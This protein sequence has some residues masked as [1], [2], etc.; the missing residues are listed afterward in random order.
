MRRMGLVAA[1]FVACFVSLVDSV[2]SVEFFVPR[3]IGP[4]I[5]RSGLSAQY[6]YYVDNA[7]TIHT[8]VSVL[9]GPT[10]VRLSPASAQAIARE[11]AAAVSGNERSKTISF[12]EGTCTYLSANN[13][14]T[15]TIAPTGGNPATLTNNDI[16]VFINSCTEATT[17]ATTWV[18]QALKLQPAAAPAAPVAPPVPE[19]APAAPVAPAAE[20]AVAED[21][22]PPVTIRPWL[23]KT[24]PESVMGYVPKSALDYLDRGEQYVHT[25]YKR[26]GALAIA[27]AILALLCLIFFFRGRTHKKNAYRMHEYSQDQLQDLEKQYQKELSGASNRVNEMSRQIQD[28]EKKHQDALD[29]VKKGYAEN[30]LIF[31]NTIADIVKNR[32]KTPVGV[33]Q[34]VQ[35]LAS[36]YGTASPVKSLQDA[37][38]KSKGLIK[39]DRAAVCDD[40]DDRFRRSAASFLI[41][42]FNT[43]V[44]QAA[45]MVNEGRGDEGIAFAQESAKELNSYGRALMHANLTD[46][47]VNSR[48]DELKAL[49]VARAGAG[50]DS[51]Q[52]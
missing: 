40:G 21:A 34:I 46:E 45:A 16:T 9:D 17:L 49:Q 11:T 30:S 7:G 8:F 43:K 29:H 15:L 32:E 14:R 44:D 23:E 26:N 4:F 12:D 27:T 22:P 42:S 2:G 51:P 18:P 19:P 41:D 52:A 5:T 20:Q 13:E 50:A 3:A 25:E 33:D 48:V 24:V 28:I 39:I 6:E 35:D 38:V 1:L 10:T 31:A 36:R 47:Y 37:R